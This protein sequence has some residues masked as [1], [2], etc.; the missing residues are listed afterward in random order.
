MEYSL[1]LLSATNKCSTNRVYLKYPNMESIN[2]KQLNEIRQLSGHILQRVKHLKRLKFW[3][4]S[5]T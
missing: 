2:S 1:L 5:E 3:N 4:M